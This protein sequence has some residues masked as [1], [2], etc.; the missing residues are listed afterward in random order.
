MEMCGVVVVLVWFMDL[1]LPM[2]SVLYHHNLNPNKTLSFGTKN[3]HIKVQ[4]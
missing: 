3:K 2:Q 1:Q 4:D